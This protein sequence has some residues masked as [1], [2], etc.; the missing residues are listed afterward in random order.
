MAAAPVI[1]SRAL[2]ACCCPAQPLLVPGVDSL[3]APAASALGFAPGDA[4]RR[5]SGS[6]YSGTPCKPTCVARGEAARNGPCRNPRSARRSSRLRASGSPPS[7]GTPLYRTRTDSK[8]WHGTA[9]ASGSG[10]RRTVRGH[11]GSRL[12]QRAVQ[13]GPGHGVGIDRAVPVEAGLPAAEQQVAG[14][15]KRLMP[16]AALLDPDRPRRAVREDRAHGALGPRPEERI[17][18][19][20]QVVDIQ[21]SAALQP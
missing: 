1:E 18:R 7:P 11:A 16:S 5:T 14:F 13:I 4:R 15:G 20:R 6:A 3:L 12:A 21:R 19:P 8:A 9:R 10:N 2:L 17:V